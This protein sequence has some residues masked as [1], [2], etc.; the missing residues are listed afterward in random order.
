[1]SGNPMKRH[2]LLPFALLATLTLQAQTSA[3]VLTI[4]TGQLQTGATS[5]A[6]YDRIETVRAISAGKLYVLAVPSTVDG[7]YFGADA[8]RYIV[9]E[10]RKK[11]DEGKEYVVGLM[12]D[13]ADFESG[14]LYI[15][16][17]DMGADALYSYTAGVQTAVGDTQCDL[18]CYTFA[19]QD[20]TKNR[21]VNVADVSAIAEIIRGND[22]ENRFDHQE[23]DVNDNGK[24]ESADAAE[25]ANAILTG[26]NQIT[27]VLETSDGEADTTLP[28]LA[29]SKKQ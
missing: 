26:A 7:Y 29:P 17:P 21:K 12:G 1:M 22:S 23:A 25:L 6:K 9:K 13:T 24:I 11:G 8:E 15:V 19:L 20:V 3:S 27:I 28:I 16:R 5:G 4:P 18:E 10:V 14:N 2:I